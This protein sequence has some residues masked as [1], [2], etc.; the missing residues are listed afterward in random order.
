MGM[1]A[2]TTRIAVLRLSAE[3]HGLRTANGD[4]NGTAPPYS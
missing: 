4:S 3:G 2:K 1:L